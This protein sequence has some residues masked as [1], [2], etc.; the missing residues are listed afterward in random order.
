MELSRRR[1]LTP[2]KCQSCP[3]GTKPPEW[4]PSE[5]ECWGET[6][7]IGEGTETPPTTRETRVAVTGGG[8]KGSTGRPGMAAPPHPQ[9]GM[10]EIVDSAGTLLRQT[11]GT[12]DAGPEH[13][14]LARC[15]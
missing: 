13:S 12:D 1:S 8:Y 4:P 7:R 9:R 3:V 6:D 2:P 10:A 15:E 5:S 14:A 11:A